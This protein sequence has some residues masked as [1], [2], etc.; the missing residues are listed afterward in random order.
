MVRR[1]AAAVSLPVQLGGGIR[2][3]AAVMA[4]LD[5]GVERVIL[6]TALVTGDPAAVDALLAE[7]GERIVVGVD[8]RDGRVAVQGWTETTDRDAVDLAREMESR[9][10][11]RLVYTDITSDGMLA[12]PNLEGIGRMAEALSIPMIAAGTRPNMLKAE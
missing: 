7:F 2:D 8:A 10:A 9:G 3:R 12:G 11:R 5:A 6:G 4:A 1:I